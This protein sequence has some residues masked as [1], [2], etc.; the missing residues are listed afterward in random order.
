MECSRFSN[1]KSW[2]AVLRSTVKE[3]KRLFLPLSMKKPTNWSSACSEG[4]LPQAW[5]TFLPMSWCLPRWYLLRSESAGKTWGSGLTDGLGH[6]ADI[7]AATIENAANHGR[8]SCRTGASWGSLAMLEA[9]SLC[10]ILGS[11]WQ[12]WCT[13]LKVPGKPFNMWDFKRVI[14]NTCLPL[15]FGVNQEMTHRS[16]RNKISAL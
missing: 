6:L 4:A 12:F 1:F 3:A 10:T 16:Q 11:K 5:K 14:N 8:R 9:M 7:R 15:E 2:L 13:S